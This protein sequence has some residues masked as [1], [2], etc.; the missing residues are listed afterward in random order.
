MKSRDVP[1]QVAHGWGGGLFN[2]E[3]DT[4]WSVESDDED[5]DDEE[6]ELYFNLREKFLKHSA[7]GST[8]ITDDEEDEEDDDMAFGL[9]DSDNEAPRSFSVASSSPSIS[10]KVL[11]DD[12]KLMKL[13]S[14]QCFNGAF[15]VDMVLAQ[16][17]DTTLEDI[18][19]GSFK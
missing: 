15:K 3:S 17:L 2:G 19:E 13:I 6:D 11:T 5:D 9:F 12:D 7:P 18:K 1:V 14:I 16:L 8:I 4:D 10:P